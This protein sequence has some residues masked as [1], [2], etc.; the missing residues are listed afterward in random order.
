MHAVGVHRRVRGGDVE[1]ARLRLGQMRQKFG[2]RTAIANDKCL[3]VLKQHMI[4][5][6]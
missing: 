3:E 2:R 6:L 1:L 5:N 4:R